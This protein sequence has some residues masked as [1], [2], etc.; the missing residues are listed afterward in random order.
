MGCVVVTLPLREK[1]NA[2]TRSLGNGSFRLERATSFPFS[3]FVSYFSFIYPYGD[4]AGIKKVEKF[5]VFSLKVSIFITTDV[6]INSGR[7][8]DL[9]TGLYDPSR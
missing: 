6:R 3:P 2:R 1:N 7:L 8:N 9:I 5:D 4:G